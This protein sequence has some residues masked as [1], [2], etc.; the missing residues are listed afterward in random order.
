MQTSVLWKRENTPTWGDQALERGLQHWG[1]QVSPIEAKFLFRG[2][3]YST[4][5]VPVD[6]TS[7]PMQDGVVLRL[8]QSADGTW[9]VPIF[10]NPQLLMK[11]GVAVGWCKEGQ[12][13]PWTQVSGKE[14]FQ[15]L[16]VI[17]GV[18]CWVNP[19]SSTLKLD[20]AAL[21]LLADGQ[22]PDPRTLGAAKRPVSQVEVPKP[23]E[24]MPAQVHERILA[25]LRL[26]LEQHPC[27]KSAMLYQSP[28]GP[29]TVGL[30]TRDLHSPSNDTAVQS[31]GR[32]L[33][34]AGVE[35]NVVVLTAEMQQT[36]GKTVQPFFWRKS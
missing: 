32:L 19:G 3:M 35:I 34:K 23:K 28:G 6:P 12:E 9:G 4:V 22:I 24:F 11:Y 31:L 36:I 30:E 33:G 5:A 26:T 20:Q 16:S 21:K 7:D 8:S 18:E 10:T 17:E 14:A 1:T 2:L 29:I 25:A 15:V 13:L 27:V